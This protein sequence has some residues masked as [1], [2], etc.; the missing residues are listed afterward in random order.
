M[1]Y[2]GDMPLL[3]ETAKRITS[4]PKPPKN[5]AFNSKYGHLNRKQRRA[6]AK[7]LMKAAR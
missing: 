7:Q 5:C 6:I 2:D 1:S 4:T 3:A